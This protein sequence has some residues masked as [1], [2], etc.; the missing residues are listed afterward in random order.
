MC[1]GTFDIVH[2][3]HVRHLMFAKE[4]ADILIASITADRHVMKG[5]FKPHFNEQLRA[6]NLSVYEMVDYVLIDDDPTPLKNLSIIQP[7]YFAV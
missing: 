4:R 6:L 1:H 3:G 7:D 2:A 5:T